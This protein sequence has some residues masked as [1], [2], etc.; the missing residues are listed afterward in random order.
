MHAGKKSRECCWPI[1]FA[2]SH[3][4][5]KDAADRYEFDELPVRRVNMQN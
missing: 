2:K 4:G 3:V 5:K 1:C